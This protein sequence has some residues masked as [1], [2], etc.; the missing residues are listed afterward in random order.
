[1]KKYIL[2]GA[3]ICAEKFYFLNVE[4]LDIVCVFDNNKQGI[5]YGKPIVRPYYDK[6]ASIII[7]VDDVFKYLAIKSQL[8]QMGYKEFENF[9]PYTIFDKK[10][11][12]A[13][14]NCHMSAIKEYLQKNEQFSDCYGFYPLAPIQQI[15][16]IEQ[17]LGNVVQHADLFVCQEIRKEY[18][19]GIEYSTEY[20]LKSAPKSCAIICIPNLHGLPKMLFPQL[21]NNTIFS[22]KLNEFHSKVIRHEDVILSELYENGKS[23]QETL[24]CINNDNLWDKKFISELEYEFWNKVFDREKRTHIVISDYIEQNIRKE[25]LFTD[26]WHISSG[27]A[28]EYAHRILHEIGYQEDISIILPILDASEVFIYESVKQALQL[29]FT[30]K[31]IRNYSYDSCT[32]RRKPMTL[33]DY[34]EA[35][36]AIKRVMEL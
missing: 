35:Y 32:Y 3:G 33:E 31:T 29:Q 10:V 14:G 34:V 17:A 12:V 16:N 9:I 28:H 6:D 19:L 26:T 1:M 2:F 21:R 36:Y 30:E 7:A 22:N 15:N 5:F 20:I 27:L 11:A 25:K 4:K 18:H 23:I 24:K 13:Y 8:L